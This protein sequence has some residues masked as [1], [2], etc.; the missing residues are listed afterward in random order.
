[1]KDVCP[2]DTGEKQQEE[3][4]G[5]RSPNANTPSNQKKNPKSYLG[6]R[7]NVSDERYAGSRK[8]FVGFHLEAEIRQIG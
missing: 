7:Q 4:T 5:N 8:H 1:M 3:N 2:G 6:E